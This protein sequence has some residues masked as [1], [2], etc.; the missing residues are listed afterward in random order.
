VEIFLFLFTLFPGADLGF[1]NVDS[2]VV[3]RSVYDCVV[4]SGML[5]EVEGRGD[6]D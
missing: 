3:T 6:S 2:G 1:E 4:I 5:F